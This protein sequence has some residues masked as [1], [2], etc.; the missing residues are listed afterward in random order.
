MHLPRCLLTTAAG[1]VAVL[2]TALSAAPPTTAAAA[3]AVSAP[4]ASTWK[5]VQRVA[6][7]KP[8]WNEGPVA[9][10]RSPIVRYLR[11][12]ERVTSCVVAVG[13]DAWSHYSDCGGGSL[14]RVV[15]GRQSPARCLERA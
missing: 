9:T 2:A 12:G 8:A 7:R 14:W 1:V 13:G 15:P 10:T 5:A 6:V 4:C 11:R 3:A